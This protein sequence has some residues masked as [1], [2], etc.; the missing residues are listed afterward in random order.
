MINCMIVDDEKPAR[1]E[2]KYILSKSDKITR[3]IEAK[4][5]IQALKL[6]EKEKIDLLFLDIKMPQISGMDIAEI[7]L[8][9]EDAPEII[10]ITAYDEYAI[11]AFKVNAI[12]YI[13]KPVEEEKILNSINSKFENKDNKNLLKFIKEKS[14][15]DKISIYHNNKIIPIYYKDILYI[16]VEDKE[17]YIYT[18]S[19][20]YATN[21]TL[22]NIMEILDEKMFFR[23]HKSFIVNIE[24]I[25]YI[26]EWFN[27]TY[28]L[29]LFGTDENI[30]VSRSNVKKFRCI[31][32]IN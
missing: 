22:N 20:K 14:V 4:D 2:L 21:H 5:G 30:P 6:L 3:I 15:N 17:T 7:L 9:K 10:F 31:M 19:C 1:D 8:F 29:K 12:D 11:D 25:E 18:N 27:S 24:K 16:T 28:N 13:L 26:Q 23:S 32:N